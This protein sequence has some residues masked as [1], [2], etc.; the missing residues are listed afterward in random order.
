VLAEQP[1]ELGTLEVDVALEG[2]AAGQ[3]DP[4]PVVGGIEAPAGEVGVEPGYREEVGGRLPRLG[5]LDD[6]ERRG[7]EQVAGL[8]APAPAP[9]FGGLVEPPAP[10]P[11]LA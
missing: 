5:S 9:P 4:Q 11:P 1:I 8:P 10:A 2:L 6:G 7:P 3:G